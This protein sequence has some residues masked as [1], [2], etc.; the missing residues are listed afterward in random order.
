MK[1]LIPTKFFN[2]WTWLIVI[3]AWKWLPA[4]HK[5]R[6]RRSRFTL[7]EWSVGSTYIN[8]LFDLFFWL[9]PLTLYHVTEYL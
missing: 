4:N 2:L 1:T 6:D 9:W 3:S 5:L 7:R 8:D